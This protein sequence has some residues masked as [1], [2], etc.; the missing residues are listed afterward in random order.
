MRSTET[1]SFLSNQAGIALK[2]NSKT[3]HNAE[4]SILLDLIQ[5]INV[6]RLDL[7]LSEINM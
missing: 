4:L 6:E 2:K 5:G 1:L 3:Q 7:A